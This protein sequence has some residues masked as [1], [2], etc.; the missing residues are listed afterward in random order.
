[1]AKPMTA[2]RP[3]PLGRARRWLRRKLVRAALRGTHYADQ[4][5]RFDIA[6]R[7]KNPWSMDSRREQG[8]FQGTNAIIEREF[9]HVGRLLELGCGE[10]HQSEHLARLCGQL[11]GLDPSA[12]AIQRARRR[13]PA[14]QLSVGDLFAQPWVGEHDRF[15]VVVGCEMLYYVADVPALLDTITRLAPACLV[16]YLARADELDG[17]LGGRPNVSFSDIRCEGV[18]WRAAWWRRDSGGAD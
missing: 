13:L 8:R 18:H 1:M 6:Y 17:L 12:R 15:D 4:H 14:A 7:F 16:T 11:H 3:G 5:D 2:D 9:G 10:G